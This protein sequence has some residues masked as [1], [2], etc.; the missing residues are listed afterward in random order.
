M[1]EAAS[2]RSEFLPCYGCSV[3]ICS[4]RLNRYFW[5]DSASGCCPWLHSSITTALCT[6][7]EPSLPHVNGAAALRWWHL[8][9]LAGRCHVGWILRSMMITINLCFL[10][11][12]TFNPTRFLLAGG[13]SASYVEVISVCVWFQRML[14]RQTLPKLLHYESVCE[15]CHRW[16]GREL[17][18][19]LNVRSRVA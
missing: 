10:C 19:K 16:L 17:C 1:C 8:A 3:Y 13:A 15:Q 18:K 5:T 9:L 2:V 6:A 7:S 14:R 11:N 12:P 4:S